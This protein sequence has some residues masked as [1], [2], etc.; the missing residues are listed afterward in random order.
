MVYTLDGKKWSEDELLLKMEDD[1]FYYGY[2]GDNSLSSSVIKKLAN[3]PNEYL[4]K[5]EDTSRF[6]VG[7][8]FHWFI[9]EPDKFKS[10]HQVDLKQRKGNTWD[11]AVEEHGK[12]YLKKDV[13]TATKMA[14]SLLS[15][16]RVQDALKMTQFEVPAVGYI[17]EYLFR[18]KADIIGDGYIIDLKTCQDV[19]WFR[20]DVKKYKYGAQVYIYCEL[21]DVSYEDFVFVAIDPKTMTPQFSTGYQDTYM[22]GKKV[23]DDG[24]WN[25]EMYFDKKVLELKDFYLERLV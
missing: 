17:N 15:N 12:V 2:M 22:Y 4:H 23:V 10:I 11:E 5:I 14:E 21:F 19:S 1:S 3:N 13:D 6:D 20:N 7:S 9:L 25:Y 16:S 24:C 8:L 18:G